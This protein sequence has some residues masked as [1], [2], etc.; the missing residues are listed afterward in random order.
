MP[1]IPPNYATLFVATGN[2]LIDL[3]RGSGTPLVVLG[4]FNDHLHE[5]STPKWHSSLCRVRTAA[6]IQSTLQAKL[7]ARLL[8]RSRT[9][10]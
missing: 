9:R 4:D 5:R 3:L 6:D 1:D 10:I 2:L 8:R 7:H